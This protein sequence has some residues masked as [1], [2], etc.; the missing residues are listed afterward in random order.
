M[1]ADDAALD[2][3][4]LDRLAA[5]SSAPEV[6]AAELAAAFADPRVAVPGTVFNA[7]RNRAEPAT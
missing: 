1:T 2:R 7:V 4:F 6:P 3:P 5:L